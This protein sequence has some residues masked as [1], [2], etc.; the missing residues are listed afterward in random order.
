MAKMTATG[1]IQ[2]RAAQVFAAHRIGP[3]IAQEGAAGAAV[4][5]RPTK[6]SLL[7]QMLLEPGGASLQSLMMATGWR[8]HYA[9][10]RIMPTCVC[11]PA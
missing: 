1:R 5:V 4:P 7:G 8:A 6:A 11:N 3:D 9:D 10:V 2:T